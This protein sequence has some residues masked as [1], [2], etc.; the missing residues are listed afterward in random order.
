MRF[1]K[2]IILGAAALGLM[3]LPAMADGW[4]GHHG[5]HH[6]GGVR[7]SVGIGVPLVVPGPYC[8]PYYPPAYYD[9]PY[10]Y[11][12]P[13]YGRSVAVGR[14]VASDLT[15]DAQRALARKGYYRGPIDGDLGP[16]SRA[17]I[18]AW[19]AD[20]GLAVTGRLDTATL[21]SL[22]LL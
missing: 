12:R 15:V 11:D 10:Y 2:S 3:A 4:R 1:S 9:A 19:Q 21:R 20:C 6:G 5:G 14:E 17:A 16:G 18:R 13:Y 8:G 7:W 22:A